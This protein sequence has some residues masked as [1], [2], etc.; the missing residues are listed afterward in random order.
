[1]APEGILA[2]STDA[3]LIK[4]IQTLPDYTSE[5]TAHDMP[6][7]LISSPD[8]NRIDKLAQKKDQAFV[9][10]AETSKIFVVIVNPKKSSG[11][12]WWRSFDRLIFSEDRWP[13]LLNG[14]V[15]LTENEK[16]FLQ[17]IR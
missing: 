10:K 14:E 13:K 7:V 9:V 1:M 2:N 4:F 3:E 8:D 5:V 6:S 12:W 15:D 17:S 16:K 11:F